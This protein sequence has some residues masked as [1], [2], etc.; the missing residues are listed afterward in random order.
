MQ[1]TLKFINVNLIL[2]ILEIKEKTKINLESSKI[3]SD[4]KEK[5]N[6]STEIK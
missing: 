6:L 3:N 1:K 4:I 5:K 2:M